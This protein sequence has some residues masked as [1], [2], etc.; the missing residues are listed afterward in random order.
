VIRYN[1]DEY[2]HS[3]CFCSRWFSFWVIALPCMFVVCFIERTLRTHS[4][5]VLWF[6]WGTNC[7]VTI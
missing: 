5:S 7:Y 1:L 4:F 2:M 6:L 3:V